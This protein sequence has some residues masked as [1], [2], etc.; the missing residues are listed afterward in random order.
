[1]KTV[2]IAGTASHGAVLYTATTAAEHG[3]Q[4][5]IPI[6]AMAGD[7]PYTEQYAAW[8]LVNAPRIGQSVTLTRVDDVKF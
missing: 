7:S 2:V 4:V 1:M 6:E 3:M 8:H 5:V